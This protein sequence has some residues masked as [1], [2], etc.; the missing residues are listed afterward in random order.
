M[1]SQALCI[2]GLKRPT[3]TAELWLCK[4]H[5]TQP[6]ATTVFEQGSP[7]LMTETDWAIAVAKLGPTESLKW[8]RLRYEC[9]YYPNVPK[10]MM[11]IQGEEDLDPHALLESEREMQKVKRADSQFQLSLSQTPAKPRVKHHQLR[12]VQPGRAAP[13]R[14]VAVA[15]EH[16]VSE[17]VG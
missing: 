3:F 2:S 4:Q 5:E 7:K 9:R 1:Q 14:D 12:V 13:A 15:G 17:G 6:L 16:E 11:R 8:K 10:L